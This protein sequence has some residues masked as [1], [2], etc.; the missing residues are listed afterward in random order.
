MAGTIQKIEIIKWFFRSFNKDP[1]KDDQLVHFFLEETAEFTDAEV[2]RGA[3]MLISEGKH[4][5]LPKSWELIQHIEADIQKVEPEAVPCFICASF[6]YVFGVVG[7]GPGR[8]IKPMTFKCQP[9]ENYHFKSIIMGRCT[10]LNGQRLGGKMDQVE[11]LPDIVEASREEKRDCVYISDRWANRLNGIP[12]P[13]PSPALIEKVKQ[14][15][16]RSQESSTQIGVNSNDI[17]KKE[18]TEPQR[19]EL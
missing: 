2:Q 13:N 8:T 10:C 5:Y 19:L 9:V 6:G 7:V 11:P 17:F 14:L 1:L 3:N 12:D 4:N 18:T 16:D 15:M